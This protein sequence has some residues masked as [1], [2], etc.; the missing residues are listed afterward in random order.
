MGVPMIVSPKRISSEENNGY[1]SD[2]RTTISGITNKRFH[3][4]LD[5]HGNVS[6][7]WQKDRPENFYYHNGP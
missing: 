6:G 1:D 4:C 3:A 7:R 5:Q 2:R